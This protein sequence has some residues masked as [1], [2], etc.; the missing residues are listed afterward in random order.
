MES[1]YKKVDNAKI[2]AQIYSLTPESKAVWSLNYFPSRTN[3]IV[4]SISSAILLFTKLGIAM[5]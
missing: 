5:L 4:I 2:I 1:I 3:L